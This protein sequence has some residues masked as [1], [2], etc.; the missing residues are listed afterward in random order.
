MI[1]KNYELRKLT[2]IGYNLFNSPP[3]RVVA[4]IY[5][6]VLASSSGL[7]QRQSHEQ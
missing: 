6:I 4:N 5:I 3:I 1:K 7:D 2:I